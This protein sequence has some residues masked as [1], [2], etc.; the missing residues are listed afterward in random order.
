MR[1]TTR[2]R[3]GMRAMVELARGHGGAPMMMREITERQQIPRKYLHSLL[4]DL[5]DS[6]LVRSHRG[7]HGGYV[8]AREPSEITA[9]D[10]LVALEGKISLVDC[11]GLRPKCK[12]YPSCATRSLWADLTGLLDEH[13]KRVTLADL[14]N[15]GPPKADEP[16]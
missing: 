12:M 6:D 3:Y 5:R 10:V 7:S 11:D 8:L 2:G 1:I 13:L 16:D 15:G 14:A 4:A 9:K